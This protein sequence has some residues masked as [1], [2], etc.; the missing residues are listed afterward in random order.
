MYFTDSPGA[1]QERRPPRLRFRLLR[2]LA[3]RLPKRPIQVNGRPYLDRYYLA[4][5]LSEQTAGLWPADD[6]PR[7][8]LGWMRRTWYLHRF[9]TPDAARDLHD[10]PWDGRGRILAGGYMERS[11]DRSR[12]LIEG[13]RTHVYPGGYH[14]I[15]QLVTRAHDPRAEVW[16]LLRV[17]PASGSWG[18]L[19]DGEHMPHHEYNARPALRAHPGAKANAL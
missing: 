5:P 14:R 6:Q 9:H 17:G 11:P 15:S 1:P 2:W 3:A 19:V 18:Y 8:R 10:H 12:L 13:N 16:T 7:E 4:G